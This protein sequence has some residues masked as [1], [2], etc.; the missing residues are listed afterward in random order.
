MSKLT[1]LDM[2][3]DILNDMDSDDV[4][5]IDDTVEA[6]QVAQIIKT[7]YQAMMSNRNWPHTARLVRINSSVDSS[8]PTIMTFDEDIKELISVYY[9]KAKFGETRLRFEPVKYIDPD[10]MLR[11]MY[12]RNTDDTHTEQYDG[13]N[14]QTFIVLNDQPPSYFTSFDDSTLIFDSYDSEVDSILQS[15]KTQVRAYVTPQFEVSDD[16]TPDLPEEA[17]SLLLEESKSKA[18]FKLKQTVDNKAEQ[19]SRR[20]NQWASRKAWRVNGGVKYPSYG[21]N[22]FGFSKH[23]RDPTFDQGR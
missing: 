9:N 20:Q 2:V 12:G 6:G 4:N 3:K 16:F 10:A 7:N 11:L 21:R 13:G 14:G 8:K 15:S 18:M 22:R 23:Q 1:L 17:F 5:S 19:E